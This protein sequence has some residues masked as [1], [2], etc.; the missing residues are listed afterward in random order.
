MNLLVGL[1]IMIVSN[2]LIRFLVKGKILGFNIFNSMVCK[3]IDDF[4][5]VFK[6]F[7]YDWK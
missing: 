3:I 6:Y 1:V 7:K 2:E 4:Y 5:K